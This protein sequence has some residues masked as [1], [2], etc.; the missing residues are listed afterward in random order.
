MKLA[1]LS[2]FRNSERNGQAARFLKQLGALADVWP[3]R[4]RF[5]GVH[6]DCIDRTQEVLETARYECGV[7]TE[8]VEYNHGGPQYGSIESEA[9]FAALSRIC[10]AGLSAINQHDELVWYVESDLLW[11]P[12]TVMSLADHVLTGKSKM[13]A[14]LVF[15]G[16]T[17]YDI[18]GFRKDGERF[19]PFPPYH[20][21]L[22]MEGLTEV[23]SVGSAFVIDASV[24]MKARC[25]RGGAL[26]DFCE[27]VRVKGAKIHVDASQQ[28][29]HP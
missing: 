19:G 16:E 17:F 21:G 29:V 14:P 4:V 25:R 11:T 20:R 13:V 23:D 3:S 18:W 10:N 15:A 26:V 2:F 27:D 24:A 9:R 22:S 8:L 12:Q 6:G 28:V 5:I 1:V 7:Y